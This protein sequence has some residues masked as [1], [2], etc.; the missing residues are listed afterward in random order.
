MK[1]LANRLADGLM[2]AIV[3]VNTQAHII[4]I[5]LCYSSDRV[6]LNLDWMQ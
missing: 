3:V 2:T 4:N 5:Y 1:Q 6:L